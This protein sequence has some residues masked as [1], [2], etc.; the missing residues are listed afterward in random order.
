MEYAYDLKSCWID[1]C[2]QYEKAMAKDTYQP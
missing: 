1:Y 2:V